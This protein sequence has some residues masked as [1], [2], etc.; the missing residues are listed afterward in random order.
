MRITKL[1]HCCLVVEITPLLSKPTVLHL[2][3]ENKPVR[4]MT[5]PGAWSSRQ[6]EEKNID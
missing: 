2:L 6:N 3:R 4:L 5:D 1:G